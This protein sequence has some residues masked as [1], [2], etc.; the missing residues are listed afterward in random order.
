[1]TLMMWN[2]MNIFPIF[3][4]INIHVLVNPKWFP[5]FTTFVQVHFLSDRGFHCVSNILEMCTF[6]HQKVT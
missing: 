1:M 3:R 6:D 4:K 2:I 5:Y